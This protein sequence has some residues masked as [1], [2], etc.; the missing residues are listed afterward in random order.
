MQVSQ[1]YQDRIFALHGLP[2]D[3]VSD[4]DSK[5]TSAFWK[6]LQSLLGTN[7]NLST[8]FHPQTDGQT[9]RMNSIAEDTLRH[10]VSPDQ[11]N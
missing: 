4:G 6:T 2:D 10:Y 9:E 8:A 7:I 1:L 11:Q 5:L 3:I